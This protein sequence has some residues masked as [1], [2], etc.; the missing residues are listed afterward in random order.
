MGLQTQGP[1]WRCAFLGK[2]T[3]LHHHAENM[4]SKTEQKCIKQEKQATRFPLVCIYF[5]VSAILSARAERSN[6]VSRKTKQQRKQIPFL[7]L[8][9]AF[10][11]LMTACWM[12]V[13]TLIF[14]SPHGTTTRVLPKHT[15]TFMALV[16]EILGVKPRRGGRGAGGG[17]EGGGIRVEIKKEHGF[18]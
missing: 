18:V 6:I 3:E 15:V 10:L 7:T 2:P 1:Q 11:Y 14:P 9:M 12:S 4:C 16:S 5:Q 17:G 8:A 13:C